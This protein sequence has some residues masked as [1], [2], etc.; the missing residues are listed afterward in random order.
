MFT[1]NRLCALGRASV[2]LT[3]DNLLKRCWINGAIGDVTRAPIRR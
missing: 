1:R 3:S 2:S